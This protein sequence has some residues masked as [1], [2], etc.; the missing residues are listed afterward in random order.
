VVVR[1]LQELVEDDV[2]L[3]EKTQTDT[4]RKLRV[5][6]HGET[7]SELNNYNL[8]QSWAKRRGASAKSWCCS[9]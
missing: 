9:R 8:W 2:V 3:K 6:R 1:S 7:N 4:V 5:I